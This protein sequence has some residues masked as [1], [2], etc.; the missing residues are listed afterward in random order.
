MNAGALF[1]NL[2]WLLASLPEYRRFRAGGC[3]LEDT[4]RRRLAHYLRR[5][6]GT[7]FGR[8]HGFA[9]IDGWEDYTRRVPLRTYDEFEPWIRRIAHG[10]NAV[11]TA[12]PVRLF[13]PSSGSSGPVKLIPYT[14][15][16]QREFRSA[17]A[18]W[19]AHTFLS[20]PRLLCGPAYWSLSPRIDRSSR[21]IDSTVP[22]GFDQ[23]SA[24][25]GGITRHM[26]D[27]TFATSQRLRHVAE[28]DLFWH[29]TLLMLI[30]C[31]D[32][33]LI[34]VWHPSF[35]SLLVERMRKNWQPLLHDL[36]TGAA[37]SSPSLKIRPDAARVRELAAI[38]HD[39]LHAIWPRL[40][41]ISCWADAH[42][43][44]SIH[45]LRE[46]FPRAAVQAKGLVA[47][48]AFVSIPFGDLKPLAARCHVF[49]FIE[50]DGASRAPWELEKNG[51]YS[52][53]VTTGGGLYRYR[54]GDLVEVQ[55]F[56]GA[57]P[58]LRFVGREDSVSDFF[59]EKLNENFV[60][61]VVT[62]IFGEYA[63]DPRFSLLAIDEQCSPPC[64]VLYLETDRPPPE[65]LDRRLDAALRANP[66]YQLCIELGQLGPVR[67]S[68]TA[69]HAFDRYAARMATLG[70]RTGDVKPT[71]LSR[72]GGWAEVFE[73]RKN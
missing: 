1:G 59:G 39:D 19:S 37:F 23:D 6:A 16:L 5:N 26:V 15:S 52:V 41:L 72:H 14:R 53:A 9:A 49:E 58:C 18:V 21:V 27:L 55:G 13:E 22:I 47:T 65:A 46:L 56:L 8:E 38:G 30:R 69:E 45:R 34:S 61:A 7:L 67:V 62:R 50:E 28:P 60:A 29:L 71:T 31:R 11:L 3:D 44:A 36:K 12:D 64:Y 42:A 4:Q 73:R 33:R 48:E 35:V 70:V 20:N 2:G 51:V 32:L 54:L 17:V 68:R 25:L 10:E 66:H 24:Y 63:L 43:A 57:I 40:R